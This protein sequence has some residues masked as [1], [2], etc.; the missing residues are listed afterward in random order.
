[1]KKFA[2]V[3]P[4]VV[5]IFLLLQP[6]TTPVHAAGEEQQESYAEALN[7]KSIERHRGWGDSLTTTRMIIRNRRGQESE[8][9]METRSIELPDDAGRALTIVQAPEDAEGI[10]LLVHSWKEKSDDIWLYLPAVRRVKRITSSG[11]SG[12]FL[13]SDFRF[14]DFTSTGPSE[15]G[16][17]AV[18]GEESLEN[19]FCKILERVYTE[20]DEEP[21]Q[22]VRVWLDEEEYRV[23]KIE[24]YDRKNRLEKTLTISDYRLH[25]ERHWRAHSMLMRNHQTRGETELQVEFVR[26][27]NGYEEGD[28]NT[29]ALKR[30]R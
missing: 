17:L 15:Q 27:G 9:L 7:R 26:F 5:S 16:R 1:M 4:F 24:Y 25:A 11:R 14:G 30:A 23:H 22:R 12:Y 19:C 21:Y 18:A 20:E 3:L 8:R 10:A 28:F 29:N 2:V 13:G 6:A